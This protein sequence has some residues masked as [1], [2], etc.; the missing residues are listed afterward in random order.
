MHHDMIY[1][2]TLFIAAAIV[3][4]LTA[5]NKKAPEPVALAAPSPE[6]AVL[7]IDKVTLLWENVEN[8][9]SYQI[10][11]DEK[12]VIKASGVCAVIEN[13]TSGTEYKVMMKSIAPKGDPQWL[14]SEYGPVLTFVTKGKTVL[15]TPDVEV[16]VAEPSSITLAWEPVKKAGM[17]VYTFNGGAQQQTSETTVTFNDLNFN[18]EYTF[19]IKA[20]PDEKS[21][22]TAV[23][24]EWGEIKVKTLDRYVLGTPV[25][26]TSDINTNGF[27]V[28]W[29]AVPDAGFYEYSVNGSPAVAVDD[30]K[31]VLTGLTA[32]TEY[33]VTV[34][35]VPAVSD[36]GS[37]VASDWSQIKATT[38]DL[39]V[40]GAPVL[41]SENVLATQFTVKW[42]AIEHA[43]SYMVSLNGGA[44]SSVSGN[45]RTFTDLSTETAYTVKVKAVPD[46]SQTGTYKESPLSEISVTTKKGP[47]PD[48]KGGDLSDF[49]EGSIF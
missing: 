8:A 48:D 17:Y 18:T 47:S 42:E 9:E 45:S 20:I 25:L 36:Q 3:S 23:E 28:N 22:E 26:K 44:F 7:G 41:K 4:V 14:D 19:R 13:L 1:R 16:A 43:G 29:N 15:Q 11:L 34:R 30:L 39:I 38:N 24:S 37:Y 10:L 33:T 5:C 40:L 27:T 12:T 21:V 35:A 49:E 46:A 2:K 31:A 32:A 6:V